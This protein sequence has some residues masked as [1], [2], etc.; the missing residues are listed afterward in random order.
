MAGTE[1]AI[2]VVQRAVGSEMELLAAPA[3]ATPDL[4]E[5]DIDL[6]VWTPAFCESRMS[7]LLRILRAQRPDHRIPIVYCRLGKPSSHACEATETPMQSP[8][9]S[10]FVDMYMLT[11]EYGRGVA[12]EI[13]AQVIRA[14]LPAAA[15]V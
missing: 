11:L 13:L 10:A 14:R 8:G 7:S 15:P 6:M 5:H 9:I 4:L 1:D 12:E 2:Q 3:I